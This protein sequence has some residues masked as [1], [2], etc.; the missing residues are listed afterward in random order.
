MVMKK[1]IL[2]IL[3]ILI[4]IP[5]SFTAFAVD[6][7]TSYEVTVVI[8]EDE[9]TSSNVVYNDDTFDYGDIIDINFSSLNV[10][11]KEF[12]FFTNGLDVYFEETPI[13]V[14]TDTRIHAFFKEEGQII[15]AFFDSNG[16]FL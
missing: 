6:I 5:F 4:V 8:H 16:E 10:E 7:I 14:T 9:E 3:L 12:A 11:G 1:F 13:V 15:A 2:L